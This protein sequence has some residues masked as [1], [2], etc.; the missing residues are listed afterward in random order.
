VWFKCC[1]VFAHLPHDF[2][3]IGGFLVKKK[4]DAQGTT[5]NSPR[6]THE[7]DNELTTEATNMT[8]TCNRYLNIAKILTTELSY[9]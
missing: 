3:V 2:Y 8:Q 5:P 9:Q 4:G 7:N 1:F 6:E